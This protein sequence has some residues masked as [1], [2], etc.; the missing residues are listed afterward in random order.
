MNRLFISRIFSDCPSVDHTFRN[1]TRRGEKTEILSQSG[2]FRQFLS[3]KENQGQAY[4]HNWLIA[5]E[6]LNFLSDQSNELVK[7]GGH[8]YNTNIGDIKMAEK[9]WQKRKSNERKEGLKKG[10]YRFS[11]MLHL[12]FI[13]LISFVRQR[14]STET[15]YCHQNS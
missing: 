13:K 10:I 2:Q 7:I 4:Q 12:G 1:L 5:R 3:E 6:A 8:R 11:F 15:R 9:L 14:S